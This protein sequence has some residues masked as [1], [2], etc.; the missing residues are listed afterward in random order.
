VAHPV[1]R[2][3][4]RDRGVLLAVVAPTDGLLLRLLALTWG[5][6]RAGD[7]VTLAQSGALGGV[8]RD[9][10]VIGT[11]KVAG[12]P[13]EGVV[14]EDVHDARDGHE[15]VVLGD[16][17]FLAALLARVR[18]ATLHAL[19]AI[20][21]AV[22]AATTRATA[23]LVVIPAVALL[24]VLALLLAL[25]R[26][27]IVLTVAALLALAGLLVPAGSTRSL[28]AFLTLAAVTISVFVAATVTVVRAAPGAV[29]A[30]R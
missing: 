14:V 3:Q 26:L 24:A 10:D 5:L 4:A 9:I 8:E 16:R 20:A 11:G 17:D 23:V 25:L 28:V 21:V 12:G 19:V 22:A 1:D 30:T 6:D 2:V 7:R 27:T 18:L 13:D 15:H 29:A